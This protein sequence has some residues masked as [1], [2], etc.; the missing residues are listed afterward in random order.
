MTH[1]I[2]LGIGIVTYNRRDVLH[3]TLRRVR[4]MTMH[5]PA[6]LVVADD[7]ST[8]GT[9]E[10]LRATGVPFVT[11]VNMGVAW[12]KNRALYL[13]NARLRCDVVILL[14]DDTRPAQC[15]WERDWIDAALRFGHVNYAG[16]WFSDRFLGGAGTPAD[17]IQC[18]LI[19]AQCLAVTSGAI[20]RAGYFDSLFRGF[21]H[22][23]VEFSRRLIRVGFGGTDKD[24]VVIYHL[25][26]GGVSR[27]LAPS[28]GDPAQ[29]ERNLKIAREL[30]V[31]QSYRMPWR[32]DEEMTQFLG[33]I[34]AAVA[35]HPEGFTLASDRAL[36]V[37]ADFRWAADAPGEK[38]LHERPVT[39]G[40][41][42]GGVYRGG[43]AG[44]GQIPG[45]PAGD[46]VRAATRDQ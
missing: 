5:G 23:H 38:Y 12:N 3:Q 28:F 14:E 6:E 8:D 43:G 34:D 41:G 26:H 29:I 24:N 44:S 16:P 11:G 2:R 45:Y 9:V 36:T 27:V 20:E 19:T 32:N 1:S 37:H 10:M 4:S 15:G 7:G 33:E 17:P 25:I 22:E 13:L 31:D 30:M 39:L 46:A 18:R 21:G 35:R 42:D 40:P